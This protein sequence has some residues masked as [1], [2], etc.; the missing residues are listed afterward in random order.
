[1][2]NKTIGVIAG[3]SSDSIVERLS[4]RGYDTV[5]VFGFGDKTSN[6]GYTKKLVTDL[7]N[8]SEITQFFI[9]S[10]VDMVVIATGH[11]LAISLIPILEENGIITNLSYEKCL[12]LKDKVKFKEAMLDRGYLTPDYYVVENK[13][14]LVKIKAAL[15][16]PLVV[17]SHIDTTQPEKIFNF[18]ELSKIVDHILSSGAKALVE[19]F[20]DGNDC[21]VAVRNSCGS[22]KDFGVTYYSKAKEYN[23]KGFSG[24]DSV[25]MS[26][27]QE[28]EICDLSRKLIEEFDIPS[29]VRVDFIVKDELIYILE[30][31]SV[32]VTGFNGS[33][34]PFFIQKGIDISEVMVDTALTILS[35]KN[36]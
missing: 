3:S 7:S 22:T 29:L 35:R 19:Q 36:I 8:T 24:A 20:I 26:Q 28:E 14:D 25:K 12:L 9:E 21:T 5:V 34:Y 10:S 1:M 23:L 16:Y 15:V 13:E 31:N 4:E 18:A 33:A 32:I 30:V 2:K 6:V 11:V 27:L 17:K